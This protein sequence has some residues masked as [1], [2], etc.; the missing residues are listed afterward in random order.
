MRGEEEDKRGGSDREMRGG[1]EDKRG[2]SDREMRG[3][4]DKRRG[5]ERTYFKS[6]VWNLQWVFSTFHCVE[7]PV[8]TCIGEWLGGRGSEGGCGAVID[9]LT[10]HLH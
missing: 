8:C 6:L 7:V 1:G 4:G 10:M 3:G 5:S 2:G 9:A